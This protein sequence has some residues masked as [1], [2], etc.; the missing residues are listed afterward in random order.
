MSKSSV[1]TVVV[2]AALSMLGL[3]KPSPGS[4][5]DSLEYRLSLSSVRIIGHEE[6]NPV[7][8]GSLFTINNK[9]FVISVNHVCQ[10]M[11]ALD[12]LIRA[13]G[14]REQ[15]TIVKTEPENDICVL[16]YKSIDNLPTH[17]F[18]MPGNAP[19]LF[20][21]ILTEGYPLDEPLNINYG[22]LLDQVAVPIMS[23]HGVV[24]MRL[25]NTSLRVFPGNSGSPVVNQ[26][27]QLVGLVDAADMRTN[28]GMITQ[29][30]ALME[31]VRSL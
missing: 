1:V 14:E 26:S 13:T 2:V 18:I 19:Q 3:S 8:S 15:V 11:P 5:P 10:A 31:F 4:T 16:T 6:A 30:E 22:F 23:E 27:G 20:E 25:T 24:L 7:G 9:R 12:A 29:Y 17:Y 21:K 28:N